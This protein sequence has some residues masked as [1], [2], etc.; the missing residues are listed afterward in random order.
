MAGSKARTFSTPHSSTSPQYIVWKALIHAAEQISHIVDLGADKFGVTGAEWIVLV[1]IGEGH[2]ESAADL[3]RQLGFDTAAMAK[4][5]NALSQRKLVLRKRSSSDR[6]VL[7]LSLSTAGHRLYPRLKQVAD[8]VLENHL[9]GM[10][11]DELM[12]AATLLDRIIT[13]GQSAYRNEL[14]TKNNLRS[15]RSK[16]NRAVTRT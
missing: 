14:A 7:S 15:K 12:T 9:R 8:Q 1:R 11:H 3:C 16:A 6:R 4:M 2:A 10:S 13:N 5:L